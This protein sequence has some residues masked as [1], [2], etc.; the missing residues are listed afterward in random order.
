[1]KFGF[2]CLLLVE[3]S[4]NHHSLIQGIGYENPSGGAHRLSLG[5][6]GFVHAF[7]TLLAENAGHG[8]AGVDC[9]GCRMSASGKL[10]Q[11]QLQEHHTYS[12][13]LLL[14]QALIALPQLCAQLC[15]PVNCRE[16]TD[17]I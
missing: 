4:G 6:N 1:L 2:D 5:V 12:Q 15:H 3:K 14:P 8:F 10:L 11:A 17:I 9:I 7:H 13:P 16:P